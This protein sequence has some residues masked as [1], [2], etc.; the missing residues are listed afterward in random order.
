MFEYVV[1]A[2]AV[3]VAVAV[4]AAVAVAPA[5]AA[6]PAIAVAAPV[7]AGDSFEPC[8]VEPTPSLLKEDSRHPCQ[9]RSMGPYVEA[10]R[11]VETPV[12]SSA[13]SYAGRAVAF[14]ASSS[15][16]LAS[17]CP[18]PASLAANSAW[19]HP[20]HATEKVEPARILVGQGSVMEAQLK[21]DRGCR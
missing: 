1:A 20:L 13:L 17:S 18:L 4:V 16:L 10:H 5:V 6:A 19:I 12:A 7:V 11:L 21:S 2:A 3:A 9:R 15:L 8:S 14:P